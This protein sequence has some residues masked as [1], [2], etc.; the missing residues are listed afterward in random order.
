MFGFF[1][2]RETQQQ[3]ES[4]TGRVVYQKNP[5]P[6]WTGRRFEDFAKEAYKVNPIG[7]QAVDKTARACASIPVFAT[8]QN[9]NELADSPL[10]SLLDN[11]NP[12]QSYAEFVQAAISYYRIAGNSYIERVPTAGGIAELYT[13]RPDRM[14]VK[15]G[16]TGLPSGY[17][18]KCGQDEINFDVNIVTGDSDIRHLKT[19]N[20]LDDWY[21]LSPMEAAAYNIDIHNEANTHI[22]SLLENSATPSGGIKVTREGGLSDDEFNR[23]NAYLDRNSI[24]GKNAGKPFLFDGT[25]WVP[26]GFSPTDMG[27]I[28]TKNSAARDISLA[29]GVPPLLLNIPGDSTYSNYKEARLA[30]YEDLVIPLMQHFVDEINAWLSPLFNGHKIAID[31]DQ[32]PAIAEKRREL[33]D[34]ADK[35]TDLTINE[36][37]L[38]KGYEPI[39][40]GDQILVQSSMIPLGMATEPLL[41]D[42]EGA[43]DDEIKAAYGDK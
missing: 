30:F 35:A 42:S 8:D 19:F 22:K 9:G 20:P 23:L 36:R 27:I 4:A 11:P 29:L 2:K 7:Y 1:R 39:D 38:M 10:L 5:R 18:Y 3:K 32:I 26:T 13:L 34:M 37:R 16:Q 40:G 21:G 31:I 28:D 17:T 6:T 24:G 14:V 43:T 25:E 33:W 15:T 41:D 12:L